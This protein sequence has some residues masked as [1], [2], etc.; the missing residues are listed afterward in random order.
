MC[1]KFELAKICTGFDSIE[2]NF[3][4]IPCMGQ[5]LGFVVKLMLITL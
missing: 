1:S 2:L 5:C 3:S 4:I